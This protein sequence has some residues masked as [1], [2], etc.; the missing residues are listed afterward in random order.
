MWLLSISKD[1]SRGWVLQRIMGQFFRLTT[2]RE[3]EHGVLNLRG[4]LEGFSDRTVH[5]DKSFYQSME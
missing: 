2:E 5:S 1:V 3:E 4:F